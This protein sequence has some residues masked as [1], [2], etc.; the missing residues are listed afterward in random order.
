M[1]LCYSLCMTP[2]NSRMICVFLTHLVY[3]DSFCLYEKPEGGVKQG[4]H[5]TGTVLQEATMSNG[6]TEA[7]RIPMNQWRDG[8]CN[9][10]ANGCCHPMC[11]LACWCTPL[12][13]GQVMTRMRLSH[14][15][16][17]DLREARPYW[18]AFKVIAL[19]FVIYLAID[20]TITILINPYAEAQFDPNT[21]A[22]VPRDTFPAWVLVLVG[23]RTFVKFVFFAYM[24]LLT[25]RTRSF[26][27]NRYGIQEN[28]CRGCEDCCCAFWLPC[29]TI[30]QM[31][32]HTA[33]YE[34]YN[35]ACCTE[36]GLAYHAP[37]V[38]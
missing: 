10:T 11:C 32:R 28:C 8:I 35:A 13:L 31:A 5:F 21:G 29:C 23:I 20:Q 16:K 12:A 34:T 7:H 26:I 17:T 1:H 22:Y 19:V 38:V 2:N 9:F 4:H 37:E 25:I 14:S 27:R 30:T 15:G 24:L 6:G 36:T 18:S 33:D 3:I